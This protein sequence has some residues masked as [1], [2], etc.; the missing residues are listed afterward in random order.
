VQSAVLRSHYVVR[1]S[2]TLVDCDYICW[3]SGKLI[4]QTIS[5]TP[6]LFVAKRRSTYSQGN[7]GKFGG[8]KRWIIGKSG[9][10]ENKSGNISETHKDR[11]KVTIGTYKRSFERCHPRPPYCLPFPDPPT[12]FPSPRLGVR[13]PHSEVQSKIA[14]KPVHRDK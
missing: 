11:G 1:L 4:A 2:V 5:Q 6:S 9:V 12:A 7:M 3:K 13:H 8:D 10:L 14:G